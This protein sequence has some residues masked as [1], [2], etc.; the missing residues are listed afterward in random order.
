MRT[1]V[2]FLL[3]ASVAVLPGC[4]MNERESGAAIGGGSGAL[5]GG[6]LA[7]SLGGVLVGGLVGAVAGYIVG[8]YLA[9]QR[10]RA[11]C[12]PAQAAPSCAPCAVPASAERRASGSAAGA[13]TPAPEWNARGVNAWHAGDASEALRCFTEAV[14]AD[15]AYDPGVQN[16]AYVRRA[17]GGAVAAR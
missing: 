3:A 17:A 12:A 10:E 8:D 13:A 2:A 5:L 6:V 14:R 7:E 11:C 1:P 15:P 16:L 4:Q 9:D